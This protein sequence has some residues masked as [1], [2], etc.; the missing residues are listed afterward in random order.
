MP[1]PVVS[2]V[3]YRDPDESLREAIDLCDGLKDL[4][5]DDKI[6]IKPNIVGYEFVYPQ[7]FGTLVTSALM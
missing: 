4:R 3:K 1:N 7:P 2:I 5:K 6:L